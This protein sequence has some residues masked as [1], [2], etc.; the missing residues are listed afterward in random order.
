MCVGQ[1]QVV[2]NETKKL[3]DRFDVD[4]VGRLEEY[5]GCKIE[6]D[7]EKGTMRFT[8][9]VLLQSFEDDFELP[10]GKPVTPLVAGTVLSRAK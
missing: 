9:P 8:Q 2:M 5:V 3:S 6:W 4:D 10:K 1:K 7:H